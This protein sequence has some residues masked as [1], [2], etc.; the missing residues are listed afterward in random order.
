MET[1]RALL[2][3]KIRLGRDLI[4]QIIFGMEN[5][6]NQYYLDLV[7]GLVVQSDRIQNI[8]ES[9]HIPLPAWHPSD[10]FILM[11]KFVSSLNNPL[12]Q[13]EMKSIL[14]SGKGVFRKFK[15]LLKQRKDLE[16]QWFRF[17]QKEMLNIILE[18]L[19]IHQ[20]YL[21]LTEL[22]DELD[23]LDD[24]INSDFTLCYDPEDCIEQMRE[25]DTE[26]WYELY[27]DYP[28]IYYQELQKRFRH[29]N[30]LRIDEENHI[31]AVKD[32]EGRLASFLWFT[33]KE[34]IVFLRS[35]I[36]I[37][38]YRGIGLA[39]QLVNELTQ[40]LNQKM[41]SYLLEISPVPHNN[42]LEHLFS[43]LGLKRGSGSFFIEY[44]S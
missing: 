21:E 29:H 2:K 17:K 20:D 19:E 1:R 30:P 34:S 22:G 42:R 43:S 44:T 31:L 14:H 4:E 9:V 13:E 5:Q 10:G 6:E 38:E 41:D 33:Q 37:K 23:Y 40:R 7:K 39:T 24:L 16:R 3:H 26:L 36:T 27:P 25:L 28:E 15:N 12:F 8:Q 18:W 11:E 35:L 32:M